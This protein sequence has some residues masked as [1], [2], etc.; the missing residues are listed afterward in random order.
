MKRIFFCLLIPTILP[1]TSL[2]STPLT[3]GKDIPYQS[4]DWTN[5]IQPGYKPH[6]E[7]FARLVPGMSGEE[8]RKLV[9]DSANPLRERLEITGTSLQGQIIWI[10]RETFFEAEGNAVEFSKFTVSIEDCQVT[11]VIVEFIGNYSTRIFR[12]SKIKILGFRESEFGTSQ[13]KI[14]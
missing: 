6:Q 4:T 12:S 10:W 14:K 7:V 11:V 2:A 8:A 13:D 3:A 5:I 1:L 9:R